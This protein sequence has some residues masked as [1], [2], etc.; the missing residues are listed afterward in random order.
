MSGV[1]NIG[2]SPTT[3][4]KPPAALTTVLR[5]MLLQPGDG[6]GY[7]IGQPPFLS[8]RQPPQSKQTSHPIACRIVLLFE[9]SMLRTRDG[10]GRRGA[11][12]APVENA[13]G[14][15]SREAK[16]KQILFSPHIRPG[17]EGLLVTVEAA[18]GFAAHPSGRNIALE[19]RAGAIFRVAQAL[20]QHVENVHTNV[21]ADEICQLQRPHRMVHA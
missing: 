14:E 7:F 13:E 5:L 21:Q 20:V 4:C 6:H 16:E 3:I 8:S 10:T 9:P 12:G 2:T 15:S 17:D 1:C 18:P 11:H 19:Q